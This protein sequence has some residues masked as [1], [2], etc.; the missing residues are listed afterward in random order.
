MSFTR[1]PW[2][3]RSIVS[4]GLLGLALF[5]AGNHGD[6][7]MAASESTAAP[8]KTGTARSVETV[9]QI[10]LRI[11]RPQE[12]VDEMRRLPSLLAQMTEATQGGSIP[13]AV[14][15]KLGDAVDAGFDPATAER[16]VV[17]AVA[18]AGGETAGDGLAAVATRFDAAGAELEKLSASKNS[19]LVAEDMEKRA[20]ARSDKARI[21]ELSTLM[22]SP[23]LRGE[24]RLTAQRIER[25]LDLVFSAGAEKVAAT[26]D[27]EWRETIA[28]FIARSRVDGGEASVPLSSQTGVAE[29]RAYL[30][31]RLL[32]LSEDDVATLHA[33]YA[34][35][36][37]RKKRD[38]LVAAF[39]K[40]NDENAKQAL[41][42][43]VSALKMVP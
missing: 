43:F 38:A 33:F 32:L 39:Q 42:A 21:E 37:G 26:D 18:G 35:A 25:A 13:G 31:G 23:E 7:A 30:E 3:T 19:E 17:E 8:D 12:V 11:E 22:A 6:P 1:W 20:A 24:V 28:E 34:S 29:G 27:A 36:E 14:V 9:D 2:P 5:L 4:A 10:L 41:V 15:R 16:K 40:Q